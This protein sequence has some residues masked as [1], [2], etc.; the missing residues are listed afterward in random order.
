[1]IM[2]TIMDMHKREGKVHNGA[3]LKKYDE[4]L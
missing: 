4:Q 1:M 3:Y 2:I